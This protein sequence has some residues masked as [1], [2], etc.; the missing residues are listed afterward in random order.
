M[1]GGLFGSRLNTSFSKALFI[2]GVFLVF[3]VV[4]PTRILLISMNE[5]IFE[6]TVKNAHAMS[7]DLTTQIFKHRWG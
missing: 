3:F 6:L 1:S 2:F 4:R 5:S 7:A